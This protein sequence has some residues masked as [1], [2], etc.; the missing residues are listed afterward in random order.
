M[1][2]DRKSTS[3]SPSPEI[4]LV[5]HIPSFGGGI[6]H[7]RAPVSLAGVPKTGQKEGLFFLGVPF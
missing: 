6:S 7:L 2:V 1:V 3:L 5:N 4:D